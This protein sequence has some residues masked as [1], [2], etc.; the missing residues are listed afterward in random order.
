MTSLPWAKRLFY[1]S[2]VLLPCLIFTILSICLSLK[3]NNAHKP[4]STSK[5]WPKKSPKGSGGFQNFALL[6]QIRARAIIVGSRYTGE[7]HLATQRNNKRN[8]GTLLRTFD[9]PRATD[10]RTHVDVLRSVSLF[11]NRMRGTESAR[12][13]W[14]SSKTNGPRVLV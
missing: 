2:S 8:Q 9:R 6:D 1:L 10:S 11:Q 5:K 4:H 3:K 14:N 13:S 12:N 7:R